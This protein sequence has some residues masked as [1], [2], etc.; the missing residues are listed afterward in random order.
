[1]QFD[2]FYAT[3]GVFGRYQQTKYFL[4][5]LTYMLPPIMVYTWSFSAATPSFRCQTPLDKLETLNVSDVQLYLYRPT[6]SQCQNHQP[7]LSTRECQRCF[8][9]NHKDQLF[10]DEDA[11]LI[12]CQNFVFDRT[13]YTST[14]VEEVILKLLPL[15]N[16]DSRFLRFHSVVDGV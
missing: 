8:T 15:I 16:I 7:T 3:I 4:I 13:Y 12:P 9:V 11:L 14:L 5:C 2:D 10:G 1:M 6:E